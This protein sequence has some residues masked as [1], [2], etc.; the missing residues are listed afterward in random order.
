MLLWK[1]R[2]TCYAYNLVCIVC[3][4]SPSH[5]LNLPEEVPN[6]DALYSS[7]DMLTDDL[8]PATQNDSH[9]A[10]TRGLCCL[11]FSVFFSSSLQDLFV[12]VICHSFRVF[13]HNCKQQCN[14]RLLSLGDHILFTYVISSGFKLFTFCRIS[15]TVGFLLI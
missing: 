3:S 4:W 11:S 15:V 14:L 7:L 8:P 5:A 13:Y 12:A 1:L 10:A 9:S 6:P 2:E